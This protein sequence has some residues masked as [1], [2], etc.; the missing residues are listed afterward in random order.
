VVGN[1]VLVIGDSV[2][3]ATHQAT[4]YLEDLARAAGAL[5]AGER[6]RDNSSSQNCALA[7]GGNGIM[8]QYA[9]A[10]A[11]S[12]VKVVIMDGGGADV[13]TGSCPTVTADCPLVVNASAAAQDLLARMAADGVQDVVYVFYPNPATSDLQAVMDV[14]RP[15]IQADCAASAVPCFWLDLRPVYEGNYDL[16]RQPDGTTPT[17]AGSQAVAAAIWSILQANCVAQ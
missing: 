11:D 12:P 15:L 13:L 1:E 2:F 16:Y 4:A 3:G 7:L 14:L 10:A 6:Y 17:A 9:A 8:A 5:A